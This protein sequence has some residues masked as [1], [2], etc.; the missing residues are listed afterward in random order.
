MFYVGFVFKNNVSHTV[1]P[2]AEIDAI[3]S[4][5]SLGLWVTTAKPTEGN[6]SF[7]CITPIK[8]NRLPDVVLSTSSP[9]Y[10]TSYPT[11]M[12]NAVRKNLILFSFAI[13]MTLADKNKG[14]S[15]PGTL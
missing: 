13:E 2:R 4:L 7:L 10:L 12:D 1:N 5:L 3:G 15:T 11:A 9:V 14:L 8:P 6:K